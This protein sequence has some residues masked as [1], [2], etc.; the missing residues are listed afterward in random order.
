MTAVNKRSAA[1]NALAAQWPIVDALMGGT[2][3]MRAA[4]QELLPRWP[5]EEIASYEARLKAA[6][7]FPAF[8]RTVSVMSGKPFS[9]QLT[10]SD[11]TPER[12]VEW[13]EDID[14]EGANLHAFASESFTEAIA[15]GFSGILVESPTAIPAANG[16]EPTRAEQVRA[17]VRPYFVRIRHDQILGWRTSSVSG[18]SKLT[19]LRYSEDAPEPDGEY[20]EKTVHR[21]RVLEPGSFRV[22]EY[23]DG[24]EWALKDEGV[25]GLSYIP[26][27]PIYGVRKRFMV[28]SPP[29]L[30]L[31]YLNVKHWQS[32]SDQD[33]ILHVAR[34]PIL[35]LK[36]FSEDVI[37]TVGAGSAIRG[38]H[39][40]SDVKF[41]EHSGASIDAGRQ[42]LLDLEE[43]MIQSGAELLVKKPG[44]RS[45]TESINDAEAN[46]SDLQ[47]MAENLEDSLDLAMQY[48]ADYARLPSG[49][50]I[51]LFKDYGAAT[52]SAA[53]GQLVIGMYNT[54][55]ISKRTALTEMQRRGELSPDIDAD[56]EI[57]QIEDEGPALGDL[58]D[59]ADD[60]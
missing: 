27:V 2:P 13:A 1:V 37:V 28:G 44:N 57:A 7:L 36:A 29:L 49:G 52:L 40:H 26:F 12:L 53:S 42:S 9:K 30:D 14:L 38:D 55:L 45:A 50:N 25:T 10:L 5:G 33:T 4:G 47:R 51:S 15:W 24:G 31:A 34:V 58:T 56:T 59:D 23:S 60:Q 35:F 46:K 6:T 20:G 19:Q 43:Q 17:G 21:V 48:M 41:V 18:A 39:E 32:Q 11:D 54:S 8:R 16:R 22:F 3:S